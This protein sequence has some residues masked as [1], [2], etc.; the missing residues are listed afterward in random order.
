[1]RGSPSSSA[2]GH[3]LY[4]AY[5]TFASSSTSATSAASVP[6]PGRNTPPQSINTPPPQLQYQPQWQ[7]NLTPSYSPYTPRQSWRSW[8]TDKLGAASAKVQ[9]G[10]AIVAS[11]AAAWKEARDAQRE[12]VGDN[13]GYYDHHERQFSVDA[14]ASS[15]GGRYQGHQ[16]RGSKDANTAYNGGS[17]SGGM[18]TGDEKRPFPSTSAGRSNSIPGGGSHSHQSTS[19]CATVL[20]PG[21]VLETLH[22]FPGWGVRRYRADPVENGSPR[23]FDIE[24]YISGFAISSK[25]PETAS[26]SQR[27]FVRLAKGFASLPKLPVLPNLLPD[28]ANAIPNPLASNSP[29]DR[30]PPPVPPKP[31]RK[32]VPEYIEPLIDLGI[33]AQPGSSQDLK[34]K[35]KM[36]GE[37]DSNWDGEGNGVAEGHVRDDLHDLMF[38]ANDN[39]YNGGD[40][41]SPTQH[42]HS[43]SHTG[44]HSSEYLQHALLS[45]LHD[46]LEKRLLPFWSSVLSNRTVKIA[47]WLGS[48]NA[49]HTQTSDDSHTLPDRFMN[50]KSD[51][52]EELELMNPPLVQATVS[53]AADG[54][55]V[56][57]VW[58]SWEEL[59][60]HPKGVHLVFGEEDQQNDGNESA[61]KRLQEHEVEVWVEMPLLG[62]EISISGESMSGEL[63]H[64]P[65]GVPQSYSAPS[66]PLSPTSPIGVTSTLPGIPSSTASS[67]SALNSPSM[68]RT[69][70]MVPITHAPI[71]LLSD[72]DDTIKSAGVVSGARAIFH[73]VF[74]KDLRDIVIPGMGEWY[75]S[76]WSLGVRFHYVSN[77]PYE[78]LP[79]VNEFFHLAQLPPGSIKLRS[80][81][82]RSLFNGLLSA[83]AARKRQGVMDVLDSFKDSRFFLVGDSGEQDL[84]LY[85]EMARERPHQILAVFVRDVMADTYHPDEAPEPIDDPTGWGVYGVGGPSNAGARIGS[86]L[87][88]LVA[89]NQDDMSNNQND[90]VPPRYLTASPSRELADE[91]DAVGL[92]NVSDL[93]ETP[94]PNKFVARFED[95]PLG[96][97]SPAASDNLRASSSSRRVTAP[98]A[99]N[100]SQFATGSSGST[101]RTS[102]DENDSTAALVEGVA[103]PKPRYPPSWSITNPRPSATTRLKEVLASSRPGSRSSTRN[104]S[105]FVD[106]PPTP[107]APPVI[108]NL[109]RAGAAVGGGIVRPHSTTD[110]GTD[111]F[112]PNSRLGAEYDTDSDGSVMSNLSSE[113][114]E[115][116]STSSAEWG[117]SQWRGGKK[118]MK[119]TLGLT[120]SSGSGSGTGWRST[121]RRSTG[122]GYGAA[123]PTASGGSGT[124]AAPMSEIEKKRAELQ[125]R[126]YRARNMMPSNIPLR[127]F[128]DPGECVEAAEILK[129]EG[130]I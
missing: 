21:G 28:V 93:D 91:T 102:C 41:I 26:R 128:R 18:G 99:Y 83:P 108:P 96:L 112:T 125:A 3:G 31:K 121:S 4:T 97:G 51:E 122:S 8:A 101:R 14:Y 65:G 124:G 23:P 126:V 43:H 57:R 11:S 72:I 85:A 6:Q 49:A 120:R 47:A 82:G 76:M 52:A 73:N 38:H 12:G 45:R 113:G 62:G 30:E 70:V 110:S 1:M 56:A 13:Y 119:K 129:R 42:Q 71:R 92:R 59:C 116:A 63:R 60:V 74:V 48:R 80:Y 54:S 46:N 104:G 19:G 81:A 88:K 53:T 33:D 79:V 75:A 7:Q 117:Q 9:A 64:T 61:A 24:L 16:R 40:P 35:Q 109:I 37:L 17:S 127:I 25:T 2:T 114:G 111:F 20:A 44:E 107:T 10:A 118:R 67:S 29:T 22:V 39:G 123:G 27:A 95:H 130:M 50:T 58:I 32:D 5:S 34:E 36:K 100:D 105:V 87:S 89:E 106:K 86:A 68:L 77:G 69:H 55:F 90:Q 66:L 115:S 98:A 103:V 84:E 78:I 15:S 94:K